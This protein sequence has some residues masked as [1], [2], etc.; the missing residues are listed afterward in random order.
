MHF[1]VCLS[2]ERF[3]TFGVVTWEIRENSENGGPKN[4]IFVMNSFLNVS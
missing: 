3:V 4:A 2:E 1:A